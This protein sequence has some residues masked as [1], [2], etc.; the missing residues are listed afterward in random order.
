[1]ASG[2]NRFKVCSASPGGTAGTTGLP[3][4]GRHGMPG[5][6]ASSSPAPAHVSKAHALLPSS[7]GRQGRPFRD[8]R[9]VVEGVNYR[10]RCG[11]A[12]RDVP[13]EFGPW[14]M[15]WKRQPR[16]SGDGTWDRSW[17]NC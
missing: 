16:Y 17:L 2:Q 3:P 10:Y 4:A 12:W 1:M 15:M 7:A 11:I 6:A 5:C 9:R 14:Q 8:D 13:T